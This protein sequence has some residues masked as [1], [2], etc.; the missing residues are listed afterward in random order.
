M[1]APTAAANAGAA[2]RADKVAAAAVAPKAAPRQPA[3]VVTEPAQA[4]PR[5]AVPVARVAPVA[6][7]ANNRS[8]AKSFELELEIVG[9]GRAC[10]K[11]NARPLFSWNTR[12][13]QSAICS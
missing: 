10:R 13:L 11:G 3:P 1:A 5:Q 12:P 6:A 4:V 2:G 7:A 9:R 8:A